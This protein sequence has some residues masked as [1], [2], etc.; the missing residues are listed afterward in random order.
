MQHHYTCLTLHLLTVMHV[1]HVQRV[2]FLMF[3]Q[4]TQLQIQV[5]DCAKIGLPLGTYQFQKYIIISNASWSPTILP[6]QRL[7]GYYRNISHSQPSILFHA[8][9]VLEVENRILTQVKW[10][11]VIAIV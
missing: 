11:K 2:A 3:C 4:H 7:N 10:V 1:K 5:I 8:L 9:F 6:M